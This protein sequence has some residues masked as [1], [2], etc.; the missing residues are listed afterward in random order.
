V[1]ELARI[2]N[3]IRCRINLIRFHKIPGTDLETTDEQ[4]LLELRE[5]LNAKGITATIRASR[6]QD[7]DA[8]CG[9]LSTKELNKNPK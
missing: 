4:R 7:I 1:K 5:E 8:A 2:L 9:L 3:G 6:G